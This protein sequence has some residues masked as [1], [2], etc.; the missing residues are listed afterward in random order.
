MEHAIAQ[1]KAP[2]AFEQELLPYVLQQL[3]TWPDEVRYFNDRQ[4]DQVLSSRCAKKLKIQLLLW[5]R[6]WHM[7]AAQYRRL[8]KLMKPSRVF[9]NAQLPALSIYDGDARYM[10]S[11]HWEYMLEGPLI[12]AVTDLTLSSQFTG[13][14]LGPALRRATSARS[15]TIHIDAYE[16]YRTSY[17]LY[18]MGA[19]SHPNL[20]TLITGCYPLNA[21]GMR[22]LAE[23]N[24]P[25]LR[26]L[27]LGLYS[28]FL[29][30]LLSATWCT[31][32]R[33]L[34]LDLCDHAS[35][36]GAHIPSPNTLAVEEEIAAGLSSG[37]LTAR[38]ARDVQALITTQDL[39]EL[40][41]LELHLDYQQDVIMDDDTINALASA[42][43][44][45]DLEV[46]AVHDLSAEHLERLRSALPSVR[47][48]SNN[49]L[50]DGWG[51][52]P[53]D[54]VEESTT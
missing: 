15:I 8:S 51:A 17:G 39:R 33:H 35:P 29:E 12:S 16:P 44:I 34:A 46:L 30:T 26:R 5:A 11:G 42:P 21:H 14:S 28:G 31:Q 41:H 22:V 24:M 23:R 54:D 18:H 9:K 2:A 40:T 53:T 47:V 49:A 4:I 1:K 36:T 48:V 3:D 50:Q 32:L 20:E 27:K 45:A 43:W 13:E 38:A 7:E 6:S 25:S 10:E 19:K 37:A 52:W